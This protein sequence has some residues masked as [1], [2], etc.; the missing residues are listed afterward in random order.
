MASW[1]QT[2]AYVITISEREGKSGFHRPTFTTA[3]TLSDQET[4]AE[5]MHDRMMKSIDFDTVKD[6]LE[7]VA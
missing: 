7:Y 2:A 3:A 6:A 4:K 5:K 1:T